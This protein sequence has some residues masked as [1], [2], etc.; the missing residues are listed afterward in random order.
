[1]MDTK[2]N[3][4]QGGDVARTNE[5]RPPKKDTVGRGVSTVRCSSPSLLVC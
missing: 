3:E 5:L 4:S 1:M 2:L